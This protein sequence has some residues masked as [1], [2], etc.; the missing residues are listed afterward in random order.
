MEWHILGV[1]WRAGMLRQEKKHVFSVVL[2]Y[3]F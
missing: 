3:D 2:V 1:I